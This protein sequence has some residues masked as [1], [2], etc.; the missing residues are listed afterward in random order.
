MTAPQTVPIVPGIDA[1]A[2]RTYF[3]IVFGYLDGL[4]PIRAFA[5]KG[6]PEQS[7]VTEFQPIDRAADRICRIAPQAAA[8]GRA[9]YVVPGTVTS[10]GTARAEDI[11]QTGVLVID[12]DDG[13]I[14]EKEAHLVGHLGAPSLTVASGGRT[15]N[16]HDKLHLYWRLTEPAVGED[17]RRV[18]ELRAEIARKA[19]GDPSFASLHQ[20]IRVPGTVHGKNG[21]LSPVRLV[22]TT[23]LE[24][25]LDE[26][27]EAAGAMPAM[28]ASLP[29]GAGLTIDIGRPG[30]HDLATRR[31][32]EGG[33]DGTT[34]FEALSTVIGHWVRQAR[35]G[36]CSD[37]E[38]R[39]AV[40]EHNAA[41]IVPPWS[42]QKLRREYD[43]LKRRDIENHGPVT[44]RT[45][46]TDQP[47]SRAPALSEDALA[48]TLVQRHGAT[49]RH[50]AA[51]GQWHHWDGQRWAR[52]ETGAIRELARQ[53]ARKAALGLEKPADARRIASSKTISSL[54]GISAC[55][56][57][58]AV[59][60]ADWDAHP[61]L[62]NTPKGLIDLAT[63][64]VAPHDPEKLLTQVTAASPGSGCRLWI[65]FLQEITGGDTDMQAYLQRLCGYLL[66]G[67]TSE[68]IFAFFHGTGFNGKS[69]FLS[70]ISAVLGDYAA[71]ATQT[72]FMATSNDRHLT[73]LAGLRAARLVTV[74]E[75]EQDR[76]WAEARIKTVTG[77]EK[78]RANFMHKDHFEFKPQFKLIVAGNHRPA[79]AGTGEA[80]RRRL[81]LVPF[82]VTIPEDR[83]D[84]SL[85]DKLLAEGDGVLG[86]MLDGCADW[87][88]MG[89][90]PPAGVRAASDAYLA[91]EDLLGQWL[92]ECCTV[93]PSQRSTAR[94]LYANWSSWAEQRGIA[95]G[96]QKTLGNTL[97]QRGYQAAKIAGARGWQG[98]AIR[99]H[100]PREAP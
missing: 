37:E 8:T 42:A 38:A 24:Y 31:I 64:E 78:I 70:T 72:A 16:G 91:D 45:P 2:I 95:P 40:V 44:P 58:V 32:R 19:G 50:T 75:T 94:D 76:A 25:D 12:L 69:V 57:R 80:M 17:L 65:G 73:E 41:M 55:D 11:V 71:T 30:A 60:A 79:L 47:T 53:T 59:R 97:R 52:D 93:A 26:L 96:S 77:G 34:R 51:W 10:P 13:N 54:L 61:M 33:V 35:I 100:G 21:H 3:A 29:T 84:K 6:T 66:T 49:W 74:S 98:L 1:D 14:P 82:D 67:D 5:E 23:T 7:P 56:P 4:V 28:M 46:D 81:H 15:A 68:Q 85:P 63:G 48:D 62:L 27:V 22:E 99:Q 92:E 20:P 89:L 39:A 83:R 36:T 88:R 86:W 87:L 9:I 90:A 43:A 18:A